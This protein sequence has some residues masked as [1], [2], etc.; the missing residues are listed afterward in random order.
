MFHS[1]TIM[2][3]FQNLISTLPTNSTYDF[4]FYAP[5]NI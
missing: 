2:L 4:M 5:S 1:A 3:L